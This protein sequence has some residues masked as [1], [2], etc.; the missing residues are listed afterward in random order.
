MVPYSVPVHWEHPRQRVFIPHSSIPLDS[1][2]LQ[3]THL[4]DIKVTS[5]LRKLFCIVYACPST[6]Y[7]ST[8]GTD[9]Q[10]H[11]FLIRE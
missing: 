10:L 3:K 5:V 8:T 4:C 2:A 9:L 6:V 7:S 11:E 1:N